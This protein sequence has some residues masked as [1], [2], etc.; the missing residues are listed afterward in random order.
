MVKTIF[1][2][3][4][5]FSDLKKFTNLTLKRA[6]RILKRINRNKYTYRHKMIILQNLNHKEERLK[7]HK[8]DRISGNG[9]AY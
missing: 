8:R 5:N 2:E 4:D 6:Q 7:S 3:S 9:N 1:Q